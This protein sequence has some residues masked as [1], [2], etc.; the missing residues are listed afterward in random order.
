MTVTCSGWN[1]YIANELSEFSNLAG[2]VSE[3]TGCLDAPNHHQN[4]L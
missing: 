1:V 2:A 4:P 3:L